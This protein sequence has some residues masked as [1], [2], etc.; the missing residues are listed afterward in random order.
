MTRHIQEGDPAGGDLTGTYPNP[1]LLGTPIGAT[2][3]TG[4]TGIQGDEGPQ[5]EP[6]P[7]GS[8]GPPGSSGP[9]GALGGT[10][11]P[12]ATGATGSGATGVQGA[13]GTI[14]GTGP[15]GATGPPGPASTTG[16]T[17]ATGSPGL[18]GQTGPQG[19]SGSGATGATGSSGPT[20]ATGIQ[21]ATGPSTGAA[22]G[23]LSGTY[24]NPLVSV[25][26]LQTMKI[27]F[28]GAYIPNRAL[29]NWNHRSSLNARDIVFIGDSITNGRAGKTNAPTPDMHTITGS[30]VISTATGNFGTDCVG[31]MITGTNIPADSFIW[32]RDN[33][34]QVRINNACTG[35]TTT[36]IYEFK[37]ESFP[38]KVRNHFDTLGSANYGLIPPW[39]GDFS[40]L[41]NANTIPEITHWGT[42]SAITTTNQAHLMPF[43]VG[44][45]FLSPSSS[46]TT[47]AKVGASLRVTAA[48][49]AT[50]AGVSLVSTDVDRW[51]QHAGL[52]PFT[53]ITAVNV[54]SGTRTTGATCGS[55]AGTS[56]ISSSVSEF[57]PSDVGLP[58]SGNNIPVGAI[59]TSYI[60][61]TSISIA[62]T[63]VSVNQAN[64]VFIIGGTQIGLSQNATVSPTPTAWRIEG[65][66]VKW[67]R[68]PNVDA[69]LVDIIWTDMANSSGTFSYSIDNGST[70]TGQAQTGPLTPILKRTGVS[71]PASPAP[72]TLVVRGYNATAAPGVLGT[73]ARFLW[74]AFIVYSTTDRSG[75]SVHNI[76][77]P[78]NTLHNV[79]SGTYEV[80]D[81][82][83]TLGSTAAVSP[84]ADFKTWGSK[85][86]RSP[87]IPAGNSWTW[88]SP[89]NI[90]LSAAATATG[91]STATIGSQG[92]P[93]AWLDN[94]GTGWQGIKPELV[95]VMF[96]NDM[97]FYNDPERYVDTLKYL[98]D[99]VSRYADILI[100]NPYEIARGDWFDVSMLSVGT[101]ELIAVDP[102]GAFS[103]D[104]IGSPIYGNIV[105]SNNAAGGP[106][107]ITA[108][109][110]A[111]HITVSA[112]CDA[113]AATVSVGAS[114]TTNTAYR[115]AVKAFAAANNYALL[116]L[117]D[118][119]A[120][121]GAVGA[122]GAAAEGLMSAF[123]SVHPSQTGFS[124]IGARISRLLNLFS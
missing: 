2:G 15:P 76:G 53:T 110:D 123:D 35:T 115:N 42:W 43:G 87:N 23:D 100:L 18:T 106:V 54:L 9:Q 50:I 118:A 124:D 1:T 40:T 120:S 39:Y 114:S 31:A 67:E 20:G 82:Q 12:G 94:K 28:G 55:F 16:A 47:I 14:G 68:P 13:T 96:V 104:D 57:A 29:D 77:Y 19:A 88:S 49:T 37:M 66:W 65:P 8:T 98:T 97:N 119:Y 90:V 122:T 34:Q 62:P 75:V 21:G 71:F 45:Q 51:I 85:Q 41:F 112:V 108:V 24:P 102:L 38:D 56:N 4:P 84:S 69:R 81:L 101:N 60:S 61:P 36:G 25:P 93:Y 5:G 33:I 111:D 70:W 121:E 80:D 32:K 10:G 91:T 58:L 44:G 63:T 27:A 103:V 11:P 17:G 59:I 46:S 74:D 95:I 83:T 89:T 99:R 7:Q 92:D 105:P 64:Q 116:D 107:T 3:P 6:G 117:Y 73:Y 48:T 78:G 22:G 26:A 113:G 72:T 52:Q 86:I 109:T 79:A 30:D